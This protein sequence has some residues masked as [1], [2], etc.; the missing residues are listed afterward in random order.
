MKKQH[1]AYGS[2]IFAFVFCAIITSCTPVTYF[3][4]ADIVG[5]WAN[6]SDNY[7]YDSN[8]KGE[9]WDTIDDVNEGEGINFSWSI[10]EIKESDLTLIFHMDSTIG[11]EVPKYYTLITL[12]ATTLSY[13]DKFGT[14]YSFSKQR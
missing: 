10:G 9:N 11:G 13:K 14:V 6:G 1:F 8:H 7:R 2:L 12:N 3:N 4:E 5:Y